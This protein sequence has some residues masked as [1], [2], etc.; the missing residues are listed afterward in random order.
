MVI[1]EMLSRRFP[2]FIE[3]VL[4]ILLDNAIPKNMRL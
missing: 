4:E 2:R 3:E 1:M